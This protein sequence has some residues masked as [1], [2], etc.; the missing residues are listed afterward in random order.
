MTW[1]YDA[2]GPGA[3]ALTGELPNHAV[4]ALGLGSSKEAAATLAVSS[5][6][7]DFDT[8]WNEQRRTWASWLAAELRARPCAR[9]SIARSPCRPRF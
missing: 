3:V 9:I 2:A 4:L 7:E 6:M 5:L 1:R 8:V